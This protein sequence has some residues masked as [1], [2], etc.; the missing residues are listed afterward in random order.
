VEKST[1]SITKNNNKGR[2]R[3][4]S[5]YQPAEAAAS[6]PNNNIASSVSEVDTTLTGSRSRTPSP[7]FP[8]QAEQAIT[9]L[10]AE[11]ANSNQNHDHVFSQDAPLR[12]GR[13]FTAEAVY[14]YERYS[15][16]KD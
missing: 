8:L 1:D 4:D 7:Q 16:S 10:A 2:S 3:T 5:F 13:G 15:S 9:T 6:L 14:T 11:E 12:D